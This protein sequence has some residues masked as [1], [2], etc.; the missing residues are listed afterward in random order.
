MNLEKVHGLA[1]YGRKGKATGL[2]SARMRKKTAGL[3]YQDRIKHDKIIIA[4]FLI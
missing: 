2:R 1:F 3:H 4:S